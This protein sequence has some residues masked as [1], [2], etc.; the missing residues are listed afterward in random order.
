MNLISSSIIFKLLRSWRPSTSTNTRLSPP[1]AW[2]RKTLA[3]RWS[4]LSCMTTTLFGFFQSNWPPNAAHQLLCFSCALLKPTRCSLQADTDDRA[5][6]R[7]RDS[8][9][10]SDWHGGPPQEG[11]SSTAASP[12]QCSSEHRPHLV[13]TL[14]YLDIRP[15]IEFVTLQQLRPVARCSSFQCFSDHGTVQSH[16]RKVC[17]FQRPK[18]AGSVACTSYFPERATKRKSTKARERGG[19]QDSEIERERVRDQE[20]RR[21]Q[22]RVG[23]ES[24]RVRESK[25]VR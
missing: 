24:E 22:E 23:T 4:V 13:V 7:Q 8:C 10:A 5:H 18:G 6:V 17:P 25:R 19:E 9:L 21:K 15:R 20:S 14:L 11:P 16:W 2:A 12:V 3:S 1:G